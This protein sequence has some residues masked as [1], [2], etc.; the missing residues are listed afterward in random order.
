MKANRIWLAILIVFLASA[1]YEGRLKPQSRPA[2]ERALSLYRQANYAQSLAELETGL[3]YQREGIHFRAL[4]AFDKAG[5]EADSLKEKSGKKRPS[6][7]SQIRMRLAYL[8]GLSLFRRGQYVEA[9][10]AFQAVEDKSGPLPQAMYR[11]AQSQEFE[12]DF[13]GASKKYRQ[14][15]RDGSSPQS[16]VRRAAFAL[17]RIENHWKTKN[18]ASRRQ[19]R[20]AVYLGENRSDLGHWKYNHPGTGGFILAGF[21]A[22]YIVEKYIAN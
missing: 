3:S 10:K 8:R 5:E 4:D 13:R 11:I 1:F 14:V 12:G 20:V 17:R 16:L 22:L 18:S 21:L 15:I 9:R 2:Y 7:H 6:W 19:K